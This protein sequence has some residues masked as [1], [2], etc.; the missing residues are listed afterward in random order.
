MKELKRG[1]IYYADLSPAYGSEQAGIRPVV[2]LQN[3]IG[4]HYSPTTIVAVITGKQ[5]K[6]KIP[7]HVPLLIGNEKLASS[8]ILL[9]QVRTIDKRRLSSYIGRLDEDA[10]Q[11]VN[12]ALEVSFGLNYAE[13]Q[14]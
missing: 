9:E 1:E 3:N 6:A 11:D 13:K 10:M 14:A 5:R 2:I 12:H 8:T 7:T 4:N